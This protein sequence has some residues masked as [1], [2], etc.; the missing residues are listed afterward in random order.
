MEGMRGL[1]SGFLQI[2]ELSMLVAGILCAAIAVGCNAGARYC[3]EER[4]KFF[5]QPGEQKEANPE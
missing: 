1:W 4:I 5:G 2:M 3:L